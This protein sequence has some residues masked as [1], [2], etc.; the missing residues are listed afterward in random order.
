[1]CNFIGLCDLEFPL[2]AEV[3]S[4]LVS[5]LE[6]FIPFIIRTPPPPLW[7]SSG[8]NFTCRIQT[9]EMYTIGIDSKYLN[10]RNLDLFFQK[11]FHFLPAPPVRISFCCNSTCT[12]RTLNREVPPLESMVNGVLL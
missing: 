4:I 5:G 10:P 1:M 11:S 2:D 8:Q 12:N 3:M 7:M 6:W 9:S